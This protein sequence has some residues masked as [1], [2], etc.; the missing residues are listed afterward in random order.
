[1]RLSIWSKINSRISPQAVVEEEAFSGA[2]MG[3][4]GTEG[5]A[6]REVLV[7]EGEEEANGCSGS[8][9]RIRLRRPDLATGRKGTATNHCVVC[10]TTAPVVLESARYIKAS[11]VQYV[12]DSSL[13]YN[14]TRF[15]FKKEAAG[16][17][18]ERIHWAK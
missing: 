4:E 8:K 6:D 7:E 5:G 15:G 12:Q 17:A 18:A 3:V 11:Q 10:G 9:R 13:L 1:M 16:H 2:I 14:T